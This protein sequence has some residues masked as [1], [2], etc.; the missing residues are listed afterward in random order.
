M[1][2][3]SRIQAEKLLDFGVAVYVT[4]GVPGDEARLAADT[5]VQ[6]NLWGH[7][8]HGWAS[9]RAMASP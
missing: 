2:S 7:Q 3:D 6:A 9:T 4:H 5:L 1:H 8:S